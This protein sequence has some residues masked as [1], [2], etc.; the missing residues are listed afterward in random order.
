MSYIILNTTHS[1]LRNNIPH[2]FT[3][4]SYEVD[5]ESFKFPIDDFNKRIGKTNIRNN[6]LHSQIY[7]ELFLKSTPEVV[8][9]FSKTNPY[10]IIFSNEIFQNPPMIRYAMN[11]CTTNSHYLSLILGFVTCGSYD[12]YLDLFIELVDKYRPLTSEHTAL[13][14]N[15]C[16]E[17]NNYKCLCTYLKQYDLYIDDSEISSSF[18]F[19]LFSNKLEFCDAILTNMSKDLYI[20]RPEK[21]GKIEIANPTES[22]I[23]LDSIAYLHQMYSNDTIDLDGHFIYKLLTLLMKSNLMIEFTYVATVFPL[24][25]DMLYVMFVHD[26]FYYSMVMKIRNENYEL[27]KE[28]SLSK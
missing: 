8:D 22:E 16:I 17:N 12:Q 1:Y 25:A 20:F 23:N 9:E 13:I 4:F 18:K 28:L 14:M 5:G 27:Y 7:R 11:N 6:E 15:K 3:N 24:D 26:I 2:I 21:T 10:S 19:A